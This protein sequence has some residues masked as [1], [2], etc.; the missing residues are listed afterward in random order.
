MKDMDAM[1]LAVARGLAR[2]NA[3]PGRDVVLAF[4][5]DEE[6]TGEFGAGFLVKRAPRAVRRRHDG[7]R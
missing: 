5:A 2:D 3:A 6:D 1:M 4:V 7:D